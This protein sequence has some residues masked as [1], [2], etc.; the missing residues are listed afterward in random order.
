M[1]ELTVHRLSYQPGDAPPVVK[2]QVDHDGPLATQP[3][4]SRPGC[5]ASVELFELP[6]DAMQNRVQRSRA[7]PQRQSR[8]PVH[9]WSPK[10]SDQVVVVDLTASA[11]DELAEVV[12]VLSRPWI[13]EPETA[14]YD[15]P[16]IRWQRRRHRP[17]CAVGD[18]RRHRPHDACHV[19][20]D[21]Q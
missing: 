13:A 5:S 7:A 4:P 18:Y 16:A 8:R 21:Q 1:H 2:V 3:D 20:S 9:P 14:G 10:T 19:S 17:E 6:L 12:G 11:V 15:E